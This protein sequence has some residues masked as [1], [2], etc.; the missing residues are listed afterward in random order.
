MQ[1]NS[2]ESR[3]EDEL[4]FKELLVGLWKQKLWIIGFAVLGAAAAAAFLFIN[5]TTY[6]A[7]AFVLPPSQSNIANFNYGRTRETE[8]APF[9]VK[10]IYGIFL[11]KL[12]GE[13]LHREFFNKY[14]LPSLTPDERKAPQSLLYQQF[15]KVLFVVQEGKDSD[16]RFSITALNSDPAKA[17]E[18]VSTFVERA[19]AL[20]KEET[21]KNAESEADVR[22]RSLA[23][24]I[25]DMRESS[26]RTRSD[27]IT[28]LQEALL[29]AEAIGLE[30]PAIINS[31]SSREV[32][33]GAMDGPLM[34]MRGSKALKAE[35]ENLKTRRYDDP[36]INDLRL[37]QSK[38]NFYKGLVVDPNSVAV[39]T[40]DGSIEV[41]D[42][43]I[44]KKSILVVVFSLLGG[45][46][47]ALVA[48]VRHYRLQSR[49]DLQKSTD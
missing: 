7:K 37:L 23:Q 26:Q 19:G 17:A 15:L 42:S 39:Y 9:S 3:N 21:I 10:E 34:Y 40:Q 5:K 49:S 32:D 8:L 33:I 48:I 46:L 12:D 14:Y 44:K 4:D 6:E 29:V 41:P 30:S 25:A 24:Q 47:G 35:I 18:W 27:S 28:R 38:L 13:S 2:T 1:I 20:A 36:F 45:I 22:A 43:P 11:Q 16:N 31:K